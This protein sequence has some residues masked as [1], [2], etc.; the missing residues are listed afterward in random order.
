MTKGREHRILV[1]EPSV[2]V[3]TP[4]GQV[5]IAECIRIITQHDVAQFLLDCSEGED[6]LASNL[7]LILGLPVRSVAGFSQEYRPTSRVIAMNDFQ[8]IL[9]GLNVIYLN[10]LH[11]VPVLDDKDRLVASLSESV[12][13]GWTQKNLEMIARP[14]STVK[15]DFV[16]ATSG[17]RLETIYKQMLQKSLNH[18]WVIGDK[19]LVDS[20]ITWSDILLLF[21]PFSPREA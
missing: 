18:A 2:F 12:L 20:S 19:H 15:A 13:Y 14:I 17:D 21:V 3:N 11:A 1:V 9:A 10:N 7:S 4:A 16:I 8:P 5:P 6:K